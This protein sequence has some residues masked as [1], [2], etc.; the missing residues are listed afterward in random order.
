MYPDQY[1]YTKDHEWVN[2]EGEE[3]VVGITDFAQ[4]Q[5]GDVVYLEL[6]EKGTQLEFHQWERCGHT[7]W[8]ERYVR[9]EFFS[10]LRAWLT[11]RIRET[12]RSPFRDLS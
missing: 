2:I 12:N 11:R 1:H 7:P 9:E 3:A 8:T 10:I 4:K 6:P 5:L